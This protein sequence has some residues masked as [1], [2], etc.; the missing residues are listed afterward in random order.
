ML[1][2]DSSPTFRNLNVLQI[3]FDKLV[4]RDYAGF[5]SWRNLLS[6][7]NPY[8]KRGSSEKRPKEHTVMHTLIEICNYQTTIFNF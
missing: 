5:F 1:L 7:H 8:R 2:P 4:D 3:K 6:Q